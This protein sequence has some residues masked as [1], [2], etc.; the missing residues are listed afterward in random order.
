[1]QLYV[2]LREKSKIFRLGGARPTPHTLREEGLEMSWSGNRNRPIRKQITFT[3]EEWKTVQELYEKTRGQDVRGDAMTFNSWAR[4]L[5]MWGYVEQV[6]TLIEPAT[7]R[8]TLGEIGNNINQV[9]H[10]A[11]ATQSVSEYQVA[12][13]QQQFSKVW[14]IFLKLSEDFD[15]RVLDRR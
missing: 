4:Q 12:Q 7:I 6:V 8:K 15:E 9:A 13:L 5:L 3:E 2:Q 11:N 1:M 14:D 10:V